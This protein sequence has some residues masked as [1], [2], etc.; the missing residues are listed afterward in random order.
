MREGNIAEGNEII[1]RMRNRSECPAAL[2]L[3][4]AY[5]FRRPGK[6]QRHPADSKNY[7]CTG[8]LKLEILR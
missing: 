2:T 5:R 3:A 7:A 4:R 1:L 6:R 8:N